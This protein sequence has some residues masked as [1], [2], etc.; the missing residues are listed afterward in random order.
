MKKIPIAIYRGGTSRAIFFHEKDLPNSVAEQDEIIMQAIGSGHALQVNGLGGGNP[1]TSKCAIIG[2]PSVP[3]A[4]INYTFVYPG[5]VRKIA[6][7][8]GNCGNISS[9]VGPF[10]VNE[11]LVPATGDQA[12]VV[13]Y[14]TNTK[15]LL[16]ATFA[17]RSGRFYPKG[18]YAID[19]APGTGSRVSLEFLNNPETA[20]LP[21]GK[22][23]EKLEVPGVSRELD[24]TIL[25]AGNLAV[26]CSMAALGIQGEPDS[27]EKDSEL[28]LKMEAVRGAAAVRLGMAETPEEARLKTPAVPKVLAVRRP[29]PYKDL[30]G[31]QQPAETHQLMILTAAM[32]VMHRSIAVTGSVATAAAAVL[33]G[34]VVADLRSGEGPEVVIGHSSGQIALTAELDGKAGKWQARRIA[35]NRTAREI[36]KGHV[37]IEED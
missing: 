8:K 3:A 23:R 14:N 12:S 17:T 20:L 24:V 6:D 37:Y 27:W 25:Q 13:I 30:L 1:L 35:L 28:W 36:M 11:G 22:V 34:S 10:A 7:R 4:D 18:D 26:F 33:P 16:R 15:T 19:G 32:G 5:V 2:P 21:T 29:Q 9:A 31:R